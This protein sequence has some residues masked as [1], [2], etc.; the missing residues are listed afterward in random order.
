MIYEYACDE[1]KTAFD[2][3]CRP[4]DRHKQRCPQ[5]GALAA[6]LMANLAVTGTRDNFGIKKE[7][8]DEDGKTI[9][10]WKTWEKAGFRNPL[11][12]HKSHTIKEKIKKKMEKINKGLS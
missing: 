10:N 1:C 4:E 2:K 6:K 11:H 8:T 3:I 7:F 9:D 5:C 12:T